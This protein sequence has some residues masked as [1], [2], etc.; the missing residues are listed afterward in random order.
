MQTFGTIGLIETI[1]EFTYVWTNEESFTEFEKVFF[2]ATGS[3]EMAGEIMFLLVGFALLRDAPSRTSRCHY[4]K[5]LVKDP[6][7]AVAGYK[8]MSDPSEERYQMAYAGNCFNALWISTIPMFCWATYYPIW[9]HAFRGDLLFRLT[10]CGTCSILALITIALFVWRRQWWGINDLSSQLVAL[11][12][13]YYVLQKIFEVCLLLVHHDRLCPSD[14]GNALLM[15]QVTEILSVPVFYSRVFRGNMFAA[16]EEVAPILP[17]VR[18][19]T[20]LEFM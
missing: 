2:I 10:L 8:P 5:M 7:H 19:A 4:W 6:I 14:L 13:I 18:I 9:G 17:H 12:P 20:Q 3:C 1:V 11:V 15:F 16:S